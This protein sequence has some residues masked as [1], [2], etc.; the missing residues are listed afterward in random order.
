MKFYYP[1]GSKFDFDEK[2]FVEYYKDDYFLFKETYRI[3]GLHRSNP[4][5]ENAIEDILKKGETNEAYDI[6]DVSRLL[7]WKIGK[8][9]HEE[10]NDRFEYYDDWS[11]AG[12]I[13]DEQN[14]EKVELLKEITIRKKPFTLGDIATYIVNDPDNLKQLAKRD[15]PR[16]FLNTIRKDF[17]GLGTVYI[18]TLLFFLSGGK[19]P[20][21][22][23]FAH[24]AAKAIILN[25]SPN[26][27]YVGPAPDKKETD[28]ILSMY[29]EYR[30]LLSQIFG[31]SNIERKQ[32][33]ALWVYGHSKIKY[34][35]CVS[36][37]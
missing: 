7:A 23:Q 3:P 17:K 8:I 25:K 33:R 19:H 4:Y 20:I 32:D 11:D 10:S 15:N 16:D 13:E 22:D 30:W 37:E 27:I 1:D 24:K 35:D 5:I 34:S 14:R 6:R 12:L 28:K 18:L 21:Y 26:D 9:K 2:K 31:N 29:N 36:T